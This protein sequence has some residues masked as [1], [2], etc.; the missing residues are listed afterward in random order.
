MRLNVCQGIFVHSS[1]SRPGTINMAKLAGPGQLANAPPAPRILICGG[2]AS[3]LCALLL[4]PSSLLLFTFVWPL[5][6]KFF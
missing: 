5:C 6:R 3:D 1:L 4:V 2:E